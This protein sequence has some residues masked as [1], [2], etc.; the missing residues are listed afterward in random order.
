MKQETI[1]LRNMCC[2]RCVEAVID[3]LQ[4]LGVMVDKV[5]LGEA[6]FTS[7]GRVN[8]ATIEASLNKR[9]FILVK[10]EEEILVENIKSAILD[11]IHRLPEMKKTELSHSAYLE[12]ITH[13]PYR[14]LLKVF[15]K[16]KGFTIEKYFTLQKIEKVKE[17]IEGTNLQFSEIADIIGYK[18]LSHL[19]NQFKS[20]TKMTMFEYKKNPNKERKFINEI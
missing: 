16:H 8:M 14:H 6:K 5:K 12:N 2:Q 18:S 7:S 1:H 4:S 15:V 19:S 9:G 3:E 20:I 13:K 11:L 10:D 17:L